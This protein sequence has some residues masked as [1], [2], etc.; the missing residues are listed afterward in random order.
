VARSFEHAYRGMI[1]AVRTQRN[2][3]FH[4]VVA[5]LILVAS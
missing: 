4:V 5:V 1:Y 2:M 3:R